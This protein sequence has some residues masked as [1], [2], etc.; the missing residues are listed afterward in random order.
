MTGFPERD[1]MRGCAPIPAYARRFR[2]A[3]ASSAIHGSFPRDYCTVVVT[4]ALLYGPAV[5]AAGMPPAAHPFPPSGSRTLGCRR[6]PSPRALARSFRQSR[7][8]SAL[9]GSCS[10]QPPGI[11]SRKEAA[12]AR[13]P[14]PFLSPL[15]KQCQY[16]G[17]RIVNMTP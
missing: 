1:V 5:P 14:A 16:F 3:P 6:P 2:H 15:A 13:G 10:A 8:I 9:L 4:V 17:L 12:F 7:L 11:Y